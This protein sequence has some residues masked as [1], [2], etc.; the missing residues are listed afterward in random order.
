MRKMNGTR[1]RI[2]IISA[3]VLW[4]LTTAST[5][6]AGSSS[7]S[8]ELLVR[9]ETGI[10]NWSPGQ[11]QRDCDSSIVISQSAYNIISQSGPVVIERLFENQD[12]IEQVVTNPAG[13]PVKRPSFYG[14]YK[15]TFSD[16]MHA[17]MVREGLSGLDEIQS[18]CQLEEGRFGEIIPN[19]S[20]FVRQW[21]LRAGWE[22][23]DTLYADIDATYAWEIETGDS[24]VI[25]SIHDSGVK[26]D[27][28]DLVDR[29][30]GD[31]SI[32]GSRHG[33]FIAGIMGAIPNNYV[34]IAGLNWNSTIV[35]YK[36]GDTSALFTPTISSIIDAA[37]MGVTASNNSHTWENDYLL[38]KSA[39]LYAY[40]MGVLSCAIAGNDTSL[41]QKYPAAY[42]GV[43]AVSAT[44]GNGEFAQSYSNYGPHIDVSAPGG[45]DSGPGWQ[46]Y[47]TG[48]YYDED[49]YFYGKGTSY[50][51]PLVVALAGLLKSNNP[52][53]WNDDIANIIMLSA[54][55][56]GVPGR[57]DYYGW[58]KINA[59]QALEIIQRPNV[60]LSDIA[61]GGYT[62]NITDSY[63]QIFYNT[64]GLADGIYTV[65]RYEIRKSVSF[66]ESQYSLEGV[67][68]RGAA[69]WGYS[70]ANP[71]LGQLYADVVD[72]SVTE[73][74]FIIRTFVYEVW[75]I[76][77]TY[78]GFYPTSEQNATMAY[79]YLGEP[80]LEPFPYFNVYYDIWSPEDRIQLSWTDNNDYEQGSIIERKDATSGVWSVIDTVP[81]QQ[82]G[83]YYDND[84]VAQRP[85]GTE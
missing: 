64:T 68:D 34:G 21:Y 51:A 30:S 83:S 77:G 70:A 10:I 5:L 71:N 72:G 25:L 23:T 41:V 20:D 78:L 55:D 82:S 85:T 42:H 27:H 57:D 18:V 36:V 11:Q 26:G 8:K 9:F 53:L 63:S 49:G 2:V 81:N 22:G 6:V 50:A 69:S 61:T 43:L 14:Y 66:S 33:T 58:G 48:F 44:N 74:E 46:M 62:Y 84:I 3:I 75:A 12:S 29:I 15:L 56:R 16:S 54:D 79:S 65:K 28:P 67:W 13:I 47:S 35:S 19:D 52:T 4:I 40:N 73:T 31:N 39:Y 45:D 24:S 32:Y 60:L 1:L 59:Q 80:E 38:L 7:T 76:D 37:D 17:R